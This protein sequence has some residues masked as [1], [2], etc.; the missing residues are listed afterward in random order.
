M[1]QRSIMRS[2]EDFNKFYKKED[3]WYV[4]KYFDTRNIIISEIIKKH[5]KKKSLELG[6][7][8]GNFTKFFSEPNHTANDISSI[9]LERLKRKFPSVKLMHGDMLDIN[10]DDFDVIF[11]IEVIYYLSEK[12]RDLFFKKVKQFTSLKKEFIFSSPIIGRNIHRYYFTPKD[13]YDKIKKNDLK[14]IYEV[15]LNYY[16]CEDNLIMKIISKSL[17]IVIKIF[18]KL[19]IYSV[20]KFIVKNLPDKFV[21]QKL[22]IVSS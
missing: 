22:F 3:P 12:E 13:I 18:E 21:Y 10:F 14:I 19:K 7:G 9:A 20:L 8:E 11:A 2:A 15:P 1:L 16:P 6:S 17:Y 4:Q 5:N